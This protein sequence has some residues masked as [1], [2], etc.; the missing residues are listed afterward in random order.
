MRVSHVLMF[1]VDVI[2]ERDESAMLQTQKTRLASE[3]KSEYQKA[4]EYTKATEA[5]PEPQAT[6]LVKAVPRPPTPLPL[7]KVVPPPPPLVDGF[8]PEWCQCLPE[9]PA[10]PRVQ[11]V[12]CGCAPPPLCRCSFLCNEEPNCSC[13][14]GNYSRIEEKLYEQ[15][16]SA[17]VRKHEYADYKLQLRIRQLAQQRRLK[18]S[19]WRT[20]RKQLEEQLEQLQRQ[21]DASKSLQD[22]EDNGVNN[23]QRLLQKLAEARL[24]SFHKWNQTSKKSDSATL[25]VPGQKV[26][27]FYPRL[28][29]PECLCA[30]VVQVCPT[31][32]F[33]CNC[34]ER[35]TC[36]PCHPCHPLPCDACPG[37]ED[38]EVSSKVEEILSL[39]EHEAALDLRGQ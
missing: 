36:P 29:Q 28:I 5:L 4:T 22:Y 6:Q 8:V 15:V 11:Q 10:C 34:P 31:D 2:A 1:V 20:E 24:S 3:L 37:D 19:K 35:E 25:V 9:P 26:Q 30:P 13:A 27:V 39:I 17:L 12:S 33:T 32:S 21:S 14:N 16:V 23:D 38:A 18:D 7:L